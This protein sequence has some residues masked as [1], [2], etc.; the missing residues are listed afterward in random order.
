MSEIGMD[1]LHSH[2]LRMVVMG[3]GIA[4]NKMRQDRIAY[5]FCLIAMVVSI[6]SFACITLANSNEGF[7]IVELFTSEGCS[8]CPPADAVL[9][10]IATDARMSDRSIY[11]LS[12]HVDYWNKL[13]WKDPYSDPAYTQRQSD[14]SRILKLENVYTPQMV[15]NGVE[16]FIGSKRQL[17]AKAIETALR[18]IPLVAVHLEVHADES[19]VFVDYNLDGVL[20]G[21]VLNI[22]WVEAQSAS[23]PDSGENS[24]RNLRHINIVKNFLTV[25][26]TD[27]TSGKISMKR[28]EVKAGSVI[29][30]VQNSESGQIFGVSS[31]DVL[32]SN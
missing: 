31:V 25:G 24:G 28:H 9:A 26:L 14:Y 20:S 2:L 1:M 23:K 32:S 21:S 29:A 30:Y 12:F 17:A 5:R 16:E 15:V 27:K 3:N 4:C 18:Q 10:E 7:A 22:A 11:C 13:G 8:S 19:N 6:I